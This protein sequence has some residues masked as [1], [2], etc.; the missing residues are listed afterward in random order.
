MVSSFK[1]F[2][3]AP[4]LVAIMVVCI[5]QVGCIKR[6]SVAPQDIR[7]DLLQLA[8]TEINY[9]PIDDQG[10]DADQFEF[11]E[12]KD[13][14]STDI[15]LT[16]VQFSSGIDFAFP[17]KTIINPGKFFIVASN[18]TEFQA[19][20][21]FAPDGIFTGKLSN[22][23]EKIALEDMRTKV[24]FL[25][26]TY[27]AGGAWPKIADGDGYSLVRNTAIS[28]SD[29]NSALS[30]RASFR[31]NGS[32][33]ADDPGIIYINEVL[34]H[35][36]PP[37]TDAVELYN[38]NNTSVDIGGWCLT[39]RKVDPNK[40]RFPAGTVVPAKGYFVVTSNSFDATD[41]ARRFSF[42]EHGDDV[43]LFSDSLG[44]TLGSGYYT[45]YTFGENENGVSLGRVVNSRGDEDFIALNA[46]TLGA[47]NAAPKVGPLVISEIMYHPKNGIDE[48]IEI[49]NISGSE[50]P[51][52]DPKFPKNRWKIEGFD[53]VFPESLS[54]SKDEK[55]VVVSNKTTSAQ[56]KSTYSLNAGVK[57]FQS[58]KGLSNSGDYL[59]LLKP[60]E[61]YID[62]TADTTVN[63]YLV[64][65]RIHFSDAASWHSQADG[66]G[67]A[68]QR[69]KLNEYGNDPINWDAAAASPGK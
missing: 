67:L 62:S 48:Y 17:A 15:D 32:P 37:D 53:F 65:E 9:H 61:P 28:S 39:D 36:D 30:W 35:T 27:G 11:I 2:G 41:F 22:S 14:G 16:D 8:I 21:G 3:A 63:P 1:A 51:L 68:L 4:Y 42:S 20:Y 58:S 64:C 54:L 49:A 12:F 25:S 45:G 24:K 59:T 19:R 29:I 69:I 10:K 40:Y 52:Y 18:N 46:K 6:T 7:P 60:S 66:T 26:V 44:M 57:V 50:I 13:T 5:F 33:G 38:P 55:I 23:G 43:Y 34:A 56:F 47:A 31:K